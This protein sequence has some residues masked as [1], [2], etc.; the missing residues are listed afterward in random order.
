MSFKCIKKVKPTMD[1]IFKF[2]DC[3]LAWVFHSK[4]GNKKLSL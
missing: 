3:K 2:E 1:G 4:L